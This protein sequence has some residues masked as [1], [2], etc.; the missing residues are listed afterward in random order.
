MLSYYSVEHTYSHSRDRAGAGSGVGELTGNT[1]I[2]V[3]S[4]ACRE[5]RVVQGWLTYPPSQLITT[6]T[7]CNP[8]G[9]TGICTI[10]ILHQCSIGHTVACPCR[11][12]AAL[13]HRKPSGPTGFNCWTL[14]LAIPSSGIPDNERLS[15]TT[16]SAPSRE[17]NLPAA[18]SEHPEIS[19]RKRCSQPI[20]QGKKSKSLTFSLLALLPAYPSPRYRALATPHLL[21]SQTCLPPWLPDSCYAVLGCDWTML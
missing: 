1:L 18:S 11:C 12:G 16:A 6:S 5:Q 2:V 21:R 7:T 10:C 13:P 4:L 8:S 14:T 19:Q 20:I 3:V 15:T 17:P 9:N